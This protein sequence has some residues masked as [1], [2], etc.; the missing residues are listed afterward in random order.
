[1]DDYWGKKSVFFGDISLTNYPYS[2][3]WS[4]IIEHASNTQWTQRPPRKRE[5]QTGGRVAERE[6]RESER[7]RIRDMDLGRKSNVG[8]RGVTGGNWEL[9]VLIKHII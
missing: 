2:R 1:M 9:L 4:H 5:G 7:Y 3:R 8:D 6:K